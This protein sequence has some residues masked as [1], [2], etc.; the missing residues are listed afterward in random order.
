[1][2]LNAFMPF[3]EMLLSWAARPQ[4]WNRYGRKQSGSARQAQL[5]EPCAAALTRR[6][7]T[8]T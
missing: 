5:S 3:V 4:H 8:V 6:G 1:M 7:G 2:R